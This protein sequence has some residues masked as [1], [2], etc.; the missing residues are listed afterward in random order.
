MNYSVIVLNDDGETIFET[1]P[2]DG[3]C[4]LAGKAMRRCADRWE[5]RGY[6]VEF[7][8]RKDAALAL[9]LHGWHRD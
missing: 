2:Y 3:D 4:E 1:K 8:E 6:E 5:K 9:H 7:R